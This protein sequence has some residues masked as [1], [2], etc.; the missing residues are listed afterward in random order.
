MSILRVYFSKSVATL[1]S[2]LIAVAPL[3]SRS[4]IISLPNNPEPPVTIIILSFNLVFIIQTN[5]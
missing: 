3:A 4:F 5:F 2:A 1:I